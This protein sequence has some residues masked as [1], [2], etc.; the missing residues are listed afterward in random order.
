MKLKEIHTP[1][2]DFS[3]TKKEN[4]EY[5]YCLKY[6]DKIIE[7][8]ASKQNEFDPI[9]DVKSEPETF[10]DFDA[11]YYPDYIEFTIEFEPY[12]IHGTHGLLSVRKNEKSIELEY[13]ILFGDEVMTMKLNPFRVLQSFYRL[14]KEKGIKTQGEMTCSED[15]LFGYAIFEVA[16]GNLATHYLKGLKVLEEVMDEAF[17]EAAK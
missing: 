8:F 15:D 7:D 5:Y 4:A 11:A 10:L 3:I 2:F 14:A 13:M 6:K 16:E 9:V 1:V 12:R 17:D